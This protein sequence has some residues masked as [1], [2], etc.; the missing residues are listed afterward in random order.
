MLSYRDYR[1][2]A[3]N[4]NRCRFRLLMFISLFST[5]WSSSDRY[6]KNKQLA[7]KLKL[8]VKSHQLNNTQNKKR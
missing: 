2:L 3:F 4:R 1:I 6:R 8:K 5:F 7:R